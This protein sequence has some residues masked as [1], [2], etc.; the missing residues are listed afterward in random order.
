MLL[1]SHNAIIITHL[2][3]LRI[4]EEEKKVETGF[5]AV[6]IFHSLHLKANRGGFR[7][8]RT[9]INECMYMSNSPCFMS[10]VSLG[11]SF[12][13]LLLLCHVLLLHCFVYGALTCSFK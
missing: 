7:F 5:G 8:L 12:F 4:G 13:P 1:R 10:E 2:N 9:V 6:L 11:G 3:T